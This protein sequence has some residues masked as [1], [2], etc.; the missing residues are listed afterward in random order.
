MAQRPKGFWYLD[1]AE[2]F[3]K[4]DSSSVIPSRK[5][6][7]NMK[8]GEYAKLIFVMYEPSPGCQSE[9]MWVE[10]TDRLKS[11]YCGTIKS[12]PAF[13]KDILPGEKVAF[14]PEHVCEISR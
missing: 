4:K 13:L 11:G 3:Y 12:N 10:V 9:R 2:E 14:G 5:F 1:S 6:R 8:V 7:E